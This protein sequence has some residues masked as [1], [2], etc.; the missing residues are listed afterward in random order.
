MHICIS[1]SFD[2]KTKAFVSDDVVKDIFEIEFTTIR[3]AFPN[4]WIE[5]YKYKQENELWRGNSFVCNYG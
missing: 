3:K 1:L 5:A 2:Q 4:T